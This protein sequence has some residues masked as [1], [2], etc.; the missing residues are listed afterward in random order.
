MKYVIWTLVI[1]LLLVHQDNW[2]WTDSRLVF[3]FMPIGLMWHAGISISAAI[4]WYL[5]TIFA[6]PSNLEYVEKPSGDGEAE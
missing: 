2:Y 4:V 3:G 6:W 5:A 1:V